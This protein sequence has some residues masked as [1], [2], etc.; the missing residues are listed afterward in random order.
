M[1]PEAPATERRAVG[2]RVLVRAELGG[3][4]QSWDELVLGADLPSPFLRSWWVGRVAVHPLFLLVVD[5]EERLL[6]GLALEVAGRFP[7]RRLRV[8]GGGTLTPD[9]LDLVAS[10]G[11]S[12]PA[13]RALAHWWSEQRRTVVDLRGVREGTRLAEVFGGASAEAS[14]V[15]PC[16]PVESFEAWLAARSPSFRKRLRRLERQAAR[17]GVRFREVTGEELPAALDTFSRLH[18]ARS[19]RTDLARELPRLRRAVAQAHVAGE[20]VAVVAEAAGRWAWVGIGF[21]TGGRL[22]L[23]QS[24]RSGEP[25]FDGLGTLLDVALIEAGCARGVHEIDFLRG[26]EPY[27]ASFVTGQRLLL[28]IRAHQGRLAGALLGGAR[29]ARALRRAVR[30]RRI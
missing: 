26:A 27:K 28:R 23:Y 18:V 16:E 22:S 19:D 1:S 14:D 5:A 11:A 21:V 2:T 3:W 7:V 17:A 30:R 4:T 13:V 20:A 15:A 6:G 29:A 8:A 10:P 12:D 9:H 24:A 25:A